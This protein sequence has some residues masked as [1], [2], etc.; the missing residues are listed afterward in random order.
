MPKNEDVEVVKGVANL[1]ADAPETAVIE[2]ARG[3]KHVLA[4]VPGPEL[5]AAFVAKNLA[6][7]NA[8][9][10]EATGRNDGEQIDR[11]EKVWGMKGEPYCAMGQYY[12]F[13]KALFDLNGIELKPTDAAEKLSA[14]RDEVADWYL[15]FSPSCADMIAAA[16]KRGQWVELGP[17]TPSRLAPGDLVLFNFG[18]HARPHRHV[19]MAVRWDGSHIL[20]VEWNT[21]AGP[22][23]KSSDPKG[24][25]GCFV[26][27]RA[28]DAG[29]VEGTIVWHG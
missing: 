6:F 21:V 1:P 12:A 4:R 8:H 27:H 23:D 3:D 25:G 13:A 20:T 19:G 18:T 2:M 15:E 11:L 14:A 24:F 7:A 16:K 29:V 28:L 5:A 17:H 9:V 26:K 22:E 10:L